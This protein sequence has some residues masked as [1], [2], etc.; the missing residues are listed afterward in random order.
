MTIFARRSSRIREQRQREQLN[1]PS[2]TAEV[3]ASPDAPS[4]TA[5]VHEPMVVAEDLESEIVPHPPSAAR[6]DGDPFAYW[7]NDRTF[8]PDSQFY[9]VSRPGTHRFWND[10]SSQLVPIINN[11]RLNFQASSAL[12][13]A[14]F[15]VP[16]PQPA[17]VRIA[18]STL[19]FTEVHAAAATSSLAAIT[20]HHHLQRAISSLASESARVIS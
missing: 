6:P 8:G 17:P 20:P 10:L 7:G 14:P 19:R 3:P 1:A 2:P 13:A 5:E 9:N 11:V 12:L 18:A 4:T 16:P 15:T